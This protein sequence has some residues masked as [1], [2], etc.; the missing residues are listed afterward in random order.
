[1]RAIF[2]SA[3]YTGLLAAT[4]ITLCSAQADQPTATVVEQQS[5]GMVMHRGEETLRVSICGAGVVHIVA[6][7]GDPQS[8]SPHQP[9]LL[10]ACAPDHF[11]FSQNAK[12]ATLRT[13]ELQVSIELATGQLTF[14]DAAGHALLAES[15]RRTR[16]YTPDIINGEK[17]FHVSDRFMPAATE[18]FYG[19]G[20]HQSGVFNYR[21]NVVELAQ[22]NTDVAVP[23]LIS[24]NGY[25]I[26]WNTASKSWFDNRFPTEMTLSAQAADAIDYYFL[27]GPEIDQI[28]HQ[29]RELTGHAPLFGKWAYG[30]IQSKD[31]YRSAMELLDVAQEYRS[32][33]VPLDMIVQDWFWWAKRGD[34]AFSADYLKPYPDVPAALKTLHDEHLHAIISVWAVTDESSDLYR[35]LK[36]KNLVIPGTTDYDPT[37]PEARNLYWNHLVA[38][39]FAQGWDG[40]WLDSAEPEC[41]NGYSDATLDTL[42]LSIGNGARYTNIFPLMH[43]GNIY[44]H[45]RAATDR[46]RIFILTRSA[47]LGQQRNATTVWS[48][49]VMGTF[50]DFRH[51]IPAGLNFQLS[52]IPYWTT[53]IAGYGW[54]Y[55]RDTRDPAYQELY[56]R[57]FEFGVFCPIFRTHGHRVNNT[58][59]IFSYG[60][61]TPTL[62]AYDKLRYRMLPYIYSLA[63]RVTN[64]DYTMMRPLIMDWRT[65]LHVRDI[66]DEFLFGPSILVSPVTMA[67]AT[68]RSVYLPS[69]PAWYDFWTGARL[70][71][72][73]R[74]EAPAPLNRIPLYVKAGSIVPLGAEVEYATQQPDAPITLRIYPGADADFTLYED[75]GDNY[76]YEKGAHATIPLHWNDATGTL[77]IGARQGQYPG[78]P[79]KRNFR[80][81]VVDS[82]H[83]IGA[84]TQSDTGRTVS[85][86][87]SAVEVRV[88]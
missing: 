2:A 84:Q 50:H 75:E 88:K 27:Y 63:W 14:R 49:D 26:L 85:Y 64:E 11:Q 65:D 37:N 8:A 20:Q 28:I 70:H 35:Q 54:P 13:A 44:D 61:Q 56:T 16:V 78:M 59:E 67:G 79:A 58:N 40:F 5:G 82:T 10:H 77:S 19:L 48:G 43:T 41:C 7:P 1:M 18:G 52:G 33:H 66:G 83:G 24:T 46:K 47:F 4:T 3:I 15:D 38:P 32:Q 45:W 62:I 36:E 17:V 73:Q 80:V 51:Q 74:I 29:Y 68:T 22:A 25:G 12:Q 23:L 21:G 87:G 60:P 55:E 34:P 9:W 72:G 69:A 31:R 39:L 86:D 81:V 76:D 30:F 53:D 71:G 6:G 42:H 57:W